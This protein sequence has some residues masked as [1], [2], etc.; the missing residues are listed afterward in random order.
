MISGR[1][2]T[3]ESLRDA[4][5]K[6]GARG[7]RYVWKASGAQTRT[8]RLVQCLVSCLRAVCDRARRREW[9]R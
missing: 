8:Y 3:A 6:T 2:K 7:Q 1:E 4:V 9:N 5:T